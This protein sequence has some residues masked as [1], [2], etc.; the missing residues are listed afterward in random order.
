M[1]NNIVLFLNLRPYVVIDEYF[2]MICG[3]LMQAFNFITANNEIFIKVV[4]H[5]DKENLLSHS[6]WILF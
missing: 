2:R 6:I 1:L 5:M 3:D 4:N